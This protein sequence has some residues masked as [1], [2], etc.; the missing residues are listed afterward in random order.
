MAAYVPGTLVF[1]AKKAVFSASLCKP[2]VW[3]LRLTVFAF[4]YEEWKKRESKPQ[5]DIHKPHSD[6]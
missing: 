5:N 4:G 3:I 2:T 6:I 1:E